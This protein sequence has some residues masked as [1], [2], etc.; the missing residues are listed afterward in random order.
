MQRLLWEDSGRVRVTLGSGLRTDSCPATENSDS[1]TPPAGVWS[2]EGD[3]TPT[4]NALITRMIPAQFA[5]CQ[6]TIAPIPG[7]ASC[8]RSDKCYAMMIGILCFRPAH[9]RRRVA[10]S[11]SETGPHAEFLCGSPPRR[12]PRCGTSHTIANESACP[13]AR[14]RNL[15]WLARAFQP[16]V[17]AARH[18]LHL[19]PPRP[20]PKNW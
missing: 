11:F 15:P 1:A 3:R 13:R 17:L 16:S 6:Q 20:N 4:L 18:S 10:L 12:F 14:S 2:K 7:H 9:G 8:A 5:H 19:Q